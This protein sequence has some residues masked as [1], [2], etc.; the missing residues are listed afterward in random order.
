M[1][2]AYVDLKKICSTKSSFFSYDAFYFNL[3]KV[4][5]IK[6][7]ENVELRIENVELIIENSELTSTVT[8]HI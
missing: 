5:P 6:A 8:S 7:I 3:R 4:V 2:F 1:T